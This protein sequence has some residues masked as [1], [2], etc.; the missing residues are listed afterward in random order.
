MRSGNLGQQ[1]TVVVLEPGIASALADAF[2]DV[3]D[4]DSYDFADGADGR[5][6]AWR[7]GAGVICLAEEFGAKK[8]YNQAIRFT[9]AL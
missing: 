7:V 3:E 2:D 5:G 4:A 8:G 9:E 1:V 6:M